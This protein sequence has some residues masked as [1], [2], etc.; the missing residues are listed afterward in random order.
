MKYSIIFSVLSFFTLNHIAHAVPM[1]RDAGPSDAQVLNFALT[2]E[3][4]EAAFYEQGLAK[5][6][7]KAF[8]EAKYPAFSRGRYG[9]I[10]GHEAT[11][12]K[13][14]TSALKAAGVGAVGPCEYNFND[15]GPRSFVDTSV[16][17]EN[18]GVSAYTGAAAFLSNKDY[19]TAAASILTVE[20]RQSA[21]INSAV[22][23][24]NPW[25]T[26]FDIPLTIDQVYTLAAAFIKPGSCP[27]G[28]AALL[29]PLKAFPALSVPSS[30]RPGKETQLSFEEPDGPKMQF[31]AAFLSGSGSI[32][33]PIGDD[34]K[35]TVPE[36]LMGTSYVIITD[37]PS[38]V[39]GSV[40]VA[41]P[42]IV[43]FAFNSAGK[44]V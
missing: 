32:S 10:A 38:K 2:L 30:A 44:V 37:D 18:V 17:L 14:L 22:R 24:Y 26:A 20:A 28:N 4:L 15:N 11:H 16:A 19:L 5:H 6:S 41:G 7:Q 8:S 13:F 40:T 27:A 31:Y 29:P 35:V 33:V 1:K 3:H 9:E 42:A 34:K 39:D 36:G 43:M 23:K 12:V 21:W 25:G